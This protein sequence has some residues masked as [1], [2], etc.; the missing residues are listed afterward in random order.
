MFF[1]T[2]ACTFVKEVIYPYFMLNL[3]LL[4]ISRQS[5][6]DLQY[7]LYKAKAIR[8]NRRAKRGHKISWCPSAKQDDLVHVAQD[9]K[10]EEEEAYPSV[11]L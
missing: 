11:H 3:L 2:V 4:S 8:Y 10:G 1:V 9:T 5:N 6:Y 7:F